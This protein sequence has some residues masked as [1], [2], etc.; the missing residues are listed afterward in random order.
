MQLKL[1][2]MKPAVS[3]S[4]LMLTA[5]FVWIAAG[6]ILMSFAYTWLHRVAAHALL[7][8]GG[9]ALLALAIHH[10]GFLRVVDKNL[11]RLLPIEGK[12]CLFAFMTWKSYI[13]VAVMMA[14]GVTLRH[15]PL[16]KPYLAIVYLGIGLALVLSSV[17][18][19]RNGLT[20]GER[21]DQKQPTGQ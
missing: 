11:T 14:M 10:F 20:H 9:G 21:Q 8:A 19:L 1:N 16:P 4:V 7:F 17:R 12:R 5:G 2:L 15:S 13:L 6:V 3:K 18:Y